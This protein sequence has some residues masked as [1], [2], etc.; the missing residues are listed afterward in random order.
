MLLIYCL[1]KPL[2]LAISNMRFFSCALFWSAIIH[3]LLFWWDFLFAMH[4]DLYADLTLAIRFSVWLWLGFVL[5]TLAFRPSFP[6]SVISL[7][8]KRKSGY[9]PYLC[10]VSHITPWG[11]MAPECPSSCGSHLHNAKDHCATNGAGVQ[12][13]HWMP[14]GSWMCGL[15]DCLIRCTFRRKTKTWKLGPDL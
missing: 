9:I 12:S 14:D 4:T 2:C 5:E 13:S 11:K 6:G 15:S 7:P 3:L 1:G 10:W 8:C